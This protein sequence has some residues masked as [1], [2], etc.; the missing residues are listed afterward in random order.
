MLSK[1]L[2]SIILLLT[3]LQTAFAQGSKNPPNDDW[4]PPIDEGDFAKGTKEV[5][6]PNAN[7]VSGITGYQCFKTDNFISVTNNSKNLTIDCDAGNVCS[8]PFDFNKKDDQAGFTINCLNGVG[9]PS[10][11]NVDVEL[12]GGKT[13]LPIGVVYGKFETHGKGVRAAWGKTIKRWTDV[14]RFC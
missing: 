8:V 2:F 13:V 10:G 5:K 14:S 9:K 7:C 3:I 12:Y 4:Q 11:P 6:Y 1:I